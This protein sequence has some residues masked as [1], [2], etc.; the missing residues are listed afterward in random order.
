[1]K[2]RSLFKT[3]SITSIT[4]W[5]SVFALV[6]LLMTLVTS[7]LQHT[8]DQ[9]VVLKPTLRAY[10]QLFDPIYGRILLQSLWLALL[11]TFF[12]LLLGYPMAFMIARAPER[13]RPILLLFVMIPFWT[14]SLI[15]TYALLALLKTQGLV[16]TLLLSLHV[17]HAPLQLLYTN[18]AVLMGC[19]YN[20]LPFVILPLY[21]NIEKLDVRLLEA[22]RDLGA[23]RMRLLTRIILPLTT[24]GILAGSLL[25]FLPAMTL[26]YIPAILGGAKSLLLG[27]LIQLQFLSMRDWPGGSA[28]SIA[29]TAF[30]LILIFI[31]RRATR[32]NQHSEE[33]LA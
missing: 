29:L 18:T 8:P 31:Y 27:N 24:P 3:F 12:C 33:L 4:L 19:V 30:M 1:M 14:S 21:A 15:R 11:S 9:L 22:A 17:I 5:L 26:F 16:N 25:V 23:S 2:T 10:T 28:T 32:H 7:F 20:L 13:M 6:P